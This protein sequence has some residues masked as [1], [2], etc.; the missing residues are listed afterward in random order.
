M[1]RIS[2]SREKLYKREYHRDTILGIE[3]VIGE[4]QAMTKGLGS[5][6]AMMISEGGR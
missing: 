6:I 3:K 5:I 2:I 4:E 1:V